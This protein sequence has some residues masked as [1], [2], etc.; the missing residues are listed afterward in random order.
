VTKILLT[1]ATS[2]VGRHLMQDLYKDTNW[3]IYSL[4]RLPKEPRFYFDSDGRITV[5]HHD[6]RA[7]IPDRI[8]EQ[9]WDVDYIVHL[10]AEVSAA[11]SLSDPQSTVDT[12]VVGTYNMLELARKTKSKRFVYVS[13]GE[14]LG[15]VPF[16]FRLDESKPLRPTT[17]YAASKAAGEALVNAYHVSYGVPTIVVRPMN[18][19]GE[20]Q[21]HGFVL[22]T[23]Q[24]LLKGRTIKC[25]VDATG[26][27]DSRN[28]MYVDKF[29]SV[30]RWLLEN[31][32]EG[33]TY[34][35][36][37][38]ERD[39]LEIIEDL[40]HA[41]NKTPFIE[42]VPTPGEH[43]YVLEDTKIMIDWDPLPVD[44]LALV[45]LKAAERV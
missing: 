20:L 5:I 35:V 21:T 1:G 39:N 26:R 29:N 18:M 7:A 25:H 38:P 12:N 31:S 24:N 19:F 40:A 13:T 37:G 2:F 32:K 8:V 10:A 33:E 14:V 43:R 23:I 41:L 30:L 3:Q 17:P 22:S 6:L 34:H 27:C 45:A 36:V 42:N 11:K 16:P 28:W 15:P 4:E 9:V 44:Y